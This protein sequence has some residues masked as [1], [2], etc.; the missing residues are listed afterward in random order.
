MREN[1]HGAYSL[2]MLTLLET[3]GHGICIAY[4]VSFGQ[5]VLLQGYSGAIL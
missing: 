5:S 1:I 3:G 2:H 4:A